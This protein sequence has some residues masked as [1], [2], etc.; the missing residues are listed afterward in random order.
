MQIRCL[1][2]LGTF[3]T[4]NSKFPN[5]GVGKTSG[6]YLPLKPKPCQ[7][8][9]L[10]CIVTHF[11]LCLVGRQN[12]YF[13]LFL[14]L[15][16][17]KGSTEKVPKLRGVFFYTCILKSKCEACFQI[18]PPGSPSNRRSQRERSD[19]LFVCSFVWHVNARNKRPHAVCVCVGVNC[20]RV[21]ESHLVCH[22]HIIYNIKELGKAG[23][24]WL[25]SVIKWMFSA[26]L[27]CWHV[28]RVYV[29]GRCVVGVSRRDSLLIQPNLTAALSLAFSVIRVSVIQDAI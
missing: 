22:L 3:K 13:T 28:R 23:R 5:W 11:L 17:R 24:T 6:K 27:L 10:C 19:S 16:S 29:T 12:F 25:S 15:A 20:T 18:W 26:C 9:F 1:H 14:F 4:A 21:N 8:P 7:K 2:L